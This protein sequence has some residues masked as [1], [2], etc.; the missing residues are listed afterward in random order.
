MI[1]HICKDK[2]ASIRLKEIIDN[3]VTELHLCQACYEAREQEGTGV[4]QSLPANA[5][6]SLAGMGIAGAAIATK[7]SRY[8]WRACSRRF[9]ARSNTEASCP[10]RP[11]ETS[12]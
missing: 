5:L 11:A 3:S 1:C 2:V 7:F 12:T 6:D 8:R 9:T 10:T 4:S